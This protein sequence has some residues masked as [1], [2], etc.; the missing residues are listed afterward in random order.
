[1][2]QSPYLFFAEVVE[3]GSFATAA[4][5]L[6]MDRSNVSRRIKD[7][8]HTAGVQL[9]RRTTRKM[10]LTDLGAAFYEQCLAVRGEV[11][12]A[13]SLLL[14]HGGVTPESVTRSPRREDFGTLNLL[15]QH[16]ERGRGLSREGLSLSIENAWGRFVFD[17]DT[18]APIDAGDRPLI[19][20]GIQH[21]EPRTVAV[22]RS[23]DRLP[24]SP[25]QREV[26]ALVRQGHTP[27]EIGAALSVAPSTVTDHLRKIYAKL[28]VHSAGEL[29]TRLRD[30][31]ARAGATQ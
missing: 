10:V 1:M 21:F 3:A 26:C 27:G 9:L 25:A 18:M 8:E 7:L 14:S 6:G 30:L 4:R 29:A 2:E 31:E 22:R 13:K 12:Q 28:D 11:E 17:S 15:W 24:L 23:L 19:H 20:V 16:H 5:R